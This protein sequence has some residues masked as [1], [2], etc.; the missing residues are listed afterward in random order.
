MSQS[1]LI[2]RK[3]VRAQLAMQSKLPAVLP[4]QLYT[5]FVQFTQETDA[6]IPASSEAKT[7]TFND[8]TFPGKYK[9]FDLPVTLPVA[10]NEVCPPKFEVCANTDTRANRRPSNRP[11]FALDTGFDIQTKQEKELAKEKREQGEREE[12]RRRA[13]TRK[14]Q[15]IHAGKYCC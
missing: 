3:R 5:S 12:K 10:P 11:L 13:E 9:V 8:L 4:S 1:D 15:Q 2:A 14:D 7:T 6:I